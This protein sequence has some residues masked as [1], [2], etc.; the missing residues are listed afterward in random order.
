[1]E[2]KLRTDRGAIGEDQDQFVYIFSW[3]EESAQK[4]AAAYYRSGG[5]DYLYSFFRFL[6]YLK[7][8]FND[9][10]A[11]ERA[12]DRLRRIRQKENENISLFIL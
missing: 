7:S 11:Q 10:N 9:P 12:I 8:N 6:D 3:L 2:G 1:M 4:M 5:G